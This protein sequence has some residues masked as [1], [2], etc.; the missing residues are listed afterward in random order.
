MRNATHDERPIH[1]FCLSDDPG[2]STL[3]WYYFGL[4]RPC[5]FE[6]RTQKAPPAWWLFASGGLGSSLAKGKIGQPPNQT[7][8]T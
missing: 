3:E 7:T 1:V 6:N 5:D 4:V 8:V 2:D